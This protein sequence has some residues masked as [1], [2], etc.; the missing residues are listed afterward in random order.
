MKEIEV[1]AV[2]AG[3]AQR[4]EVLE[5]L[6]RAGETVEAG[7][8]RLPPRAAPRGTEELELKVVYGRGI[9]AGN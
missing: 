3:A 8:L 5:V 4:P 7:A 6:V 1:C 9:E 2:V